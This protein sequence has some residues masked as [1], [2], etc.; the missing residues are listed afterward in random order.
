MTRGQK[1]AVAAAILL[2]AVFTA[3]VLLTTYQRRPPQPIS[4]EGAVIRQ[5]FDPRARSPIPFVNITATSGTAS[6]QL[7]SDSSGFF[8]VTLSPKENTGFVILKFVNPEYRPL[9]VTLSASTS[10]FVA[11]LAPVS[12]DVRIE[13]PN[14]PETAI[15]DV[16]VRYSLRTMTTMNVGILAKTFQVFNTGGVPCRDHK[17]CSPDGKWKADAYTEPYDAG[18]N[19]EFS[20]VRVSCIAGPCPFSKVQ[21]NLSKNDRI[22]TVSALTWF[23]TTTFLVEAEVTHQTNTDIIREA[24]PFI[25]GDSMSF[26]LPEAGQ[27]PSV[28]AEMNKTVIVFPLG[29]EVLLPWADCSVRVDA[30]KSKLYRCELKTG[31]RFE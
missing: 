31:Y 7:K 29:P 19:N 30:D 22:L 12:A 27:G 4:L 24:Y 16:R 21:W 15:R 5:D 28:Q 23:G 14:A 1:A 10:V 11:Q 25:F 13:L 8:R 2:F 18:A 20:E 6:E 9:T 17:S 3:G 26:T